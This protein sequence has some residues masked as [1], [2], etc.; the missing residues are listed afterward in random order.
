MRT[1]NTTG[2]ITVFAA[3]SYADPITITHTGVGSGQIGGTTFQDASFTITDIV[4]TANRTSFFAGF[5][6]DDLFASISITGVGSFDFITGTRTFVTNLLSIVGF[7][8]AGMAGLD[9]FDGPTDATFAT[10]DMLTSIGPISGNA[11]LFQWDL[12][13]VNTTGGVLSFDTN[14]TE[15][16]FTAVV[17]QPAVPEPT[18]WLLVAT[19]LAFTVWLGRSSA[20]HKPAHRTYRH[21]QFY[22]KCA[23]RSQSSL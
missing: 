21:S 2:L 8:R 16:V 9:L 18:T 22:L 10:W 14:T 20:R 7:S 23:N 6:I 15:T 3:C 5:F 11:N 17:S 4:D 12:T 1:W 19:A 13:P